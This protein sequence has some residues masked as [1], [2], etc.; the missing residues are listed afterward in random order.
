VTSVVFL[1]VISLL[2]VRLS[3]SQSWPPLSVRSE[4][5]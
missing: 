1:V 3:L 2:V 5:G 4:D